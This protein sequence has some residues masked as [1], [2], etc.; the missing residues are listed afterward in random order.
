MRIFINLAVVLLLTLPSNAKAEGVGEALDLVG[1][2]IFSDLDNSVNNL[3]G[4]IDST[5]VGMRSNAEGLLAS[6]RSNMS[7]FLDKS[8]DELEGQE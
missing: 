8:I 3:F 5:V 1:A 6:A 7:D 2:D 4:R